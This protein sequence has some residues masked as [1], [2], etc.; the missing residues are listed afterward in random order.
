MIQATLYMY[1]DDDYEET[2]VSSSEVDID[3]VLCCA[4]SRPL[5]LNVWRHFK[6][7]GK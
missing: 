7:W 4:W 6:C 5:K 1:D 3:Q 2:F